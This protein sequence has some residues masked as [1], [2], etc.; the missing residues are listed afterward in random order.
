MN[1]A[2]IDRAQ[3]IDWYRRNRLRS[4][5][6][7]GFVHPE[8]YYD[9]P[10]PLRHPFVFYEGHLPAFSFNTLNVRGLHEPSIDPVL[11][12]LFERGIDP[13][14][15]DDAKRHA[16]ADWPAESAVRRFAAE[17]DARVER[18]LAEAAIDGERP[19]TILEHEQMHHET[20]LYIVHQLDRSLQNPIAQRHVDPAAP[21][22]E[23][24]SV[25]GGVATLGVN[26]GDV[27]FAWDNEMMRHAVD[28]PAFSIAK[29]P[30][31]NGDW[32]RF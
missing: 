29:Y 10:I 28:V 23:F 26:A 32:L 18:A 17:C 15:L 20:L 8:A 27:A 3:L 14:N 31:T 24:C 12:R 2:V 30:V 7:L 21:A 13:G 4:S 16:R 1:T 22:L 9:R 25:D 5:Q 11:Q 6:V 19:Y